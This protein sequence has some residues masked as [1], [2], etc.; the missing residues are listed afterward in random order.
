[1]VMA[2]VS[3]GKAT[4]SPFMQ[5]L[6][7]T[8]KNEFY[9]RPSYVFQMKDGSLLVSDENNGATYRIS[10]GDAKTAAR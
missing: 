4:I 2:K 8:E 7:N 3:G 9:G 6:L 1:V 5:G 10:Y